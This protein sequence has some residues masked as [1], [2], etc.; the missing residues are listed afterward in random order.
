MMETV[1]FYTKK[2]CSLCEEAYA[3]LKMLQHHYSFQIEVIDIYQDDALLLEYQLLIPAIHVKD[4]LITCE[5]MDLATLEK[6]LQQLVT[7]R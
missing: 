6:T 7:P 2:D 3:L 4:M 5:Q 1:T